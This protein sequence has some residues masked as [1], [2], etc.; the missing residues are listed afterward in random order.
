MLEHA[1]ANVPDLILLDLF[2][3]RMDGFEATKRLRSLPHVQHIPI[4]ALSA[5]AFEETR[6]ECLK[7][8]CNDFLAKPFHRDALLCLIEIYLN[9]DWIIEHDGRQASAPSSKTQTAPIDLPSTE[10]LT[11]LHELAL[12]GDIAQLRRTTRAL[13]GSDPKFQAFAD[14]ILT[15]AGEFQIVKLQSLLALYLTGQTAGGNR[16]SA[17]TPNP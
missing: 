13:G 15:L 4:I 17:Q 14:R 3:P 12:R 8:G 16:E 9:L 10:H 7:I 2:M 11:Q 5:N 1:E 6:Q